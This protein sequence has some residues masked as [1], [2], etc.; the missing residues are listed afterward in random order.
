MLRSE[1][2]L[3]RRPVRDLPVKP[4]RHGRSRL[5]AINGHHF[6]KDEG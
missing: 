5:G 2:S 4:T 3:P 6:Y 1:F